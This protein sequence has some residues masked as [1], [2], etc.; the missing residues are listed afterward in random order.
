MDPILMAGWSADQKREQTT[1]QNIE[2]KMEQ[3]NWEIG[4]L[5]DAELDA[6]NGGGILSSIG[7]AI[8][9]VAHKVKDALSD[10]IHF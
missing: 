3:N 6:I 1:M 7:H 10:G 8:S 4:E 9:W 5:T 2:Q